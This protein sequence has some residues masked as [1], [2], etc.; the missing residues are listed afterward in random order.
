MDKCAFGPFRPWGNDGDLSVFDID[1]AGQ[2]GAAVLK[3]TTKPA[4][5]RE[6]FARTGMP[7]WKMLATIAAIVITALLILEFGI[8]YFACL[9]AIY[10]LLDVAE[11]LELRREARNRAA[12]LEATGRQVPSIGYVG[13]GRSCQKAAWLA[14]RLGWIACP[15]RR[16]GM[17]RRSVRFRRV[18][19]SRPAS[20]L[21]QE[22]HEAKLATRI[23][24]PVQAPAFGRRLAEQGVWAEPV[25]QDVGRDI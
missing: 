14:R 9:I 7:S 15:M 5:S 3:I 20:A 16:D 13:S 17:L 21:L 10:V 12:I 1:R 8:W 11:R 24:L 18:A 23:R 22:L 4:R 25:F 6:I 2:C 19:N